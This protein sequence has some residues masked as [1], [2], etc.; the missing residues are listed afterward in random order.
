MGGIRWLAVDKTALIG[1]ISGVYCDADGFGLET[2]V[3]RLNSRMS[4]NRIRGRI[5]VTSCFLDK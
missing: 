4:V 5:F 2:A 1:D 3:A